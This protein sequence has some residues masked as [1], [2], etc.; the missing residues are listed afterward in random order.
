MGST[1]SLKSMSFKNL[2]SKYSN[3][4]LSKPLTRALY[5]FENQESS[6]NFMARIILVAHSLY[7]E[8]GQLHCEHKRRSRWNV[9]VLTCGLCMNLP[10]SLGA[11]LSACPRRSEPRWSKTLKCAGIWQACANKLWSSTVAWRRI[12][13]NYCD[14]SFSVCHWWAFVFRTGQFSWR[15]PPGTKPSYS[16]MMSI[17]RECSSTFVVLF[18]NVLYFLI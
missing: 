7:E 17:W 13:S 14:N 18:N 11:F 1:L 2:T 12:R 4:S 10:E 16:S 9:I 6:L 3:S 15:C 5:V 8:L